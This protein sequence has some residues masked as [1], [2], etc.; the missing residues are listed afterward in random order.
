MSRRLS[1]FCTKK[2]LSGNAEAQ[3][4]RW[5]V[6]VRYAVTNTCEVPVVLGGVLPGHQSLQWGHILHQGRN[7]QGSK[8]AGDLEKLG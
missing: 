3:T 4:D 8:K 7:T 2:N 5:Y 6:G 1:P